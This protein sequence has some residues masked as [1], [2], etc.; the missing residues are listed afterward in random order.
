MT[1]IN[2]FSAPGADGYFISYQGAQKLL[3]FMEK[4]GYSGDL[5]WRLVGYAVSPA[6]LER[7]HQDRVATGV[8]VQL[9]RM[10][11][12]PEPEFRAFSMFPSLIRDEAVDSVIFEQNAAAIARI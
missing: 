2:N 4:D 5:D 12:P 6:D 8:I 9:H 11:G 10:Y 7:M 3:K 1:K